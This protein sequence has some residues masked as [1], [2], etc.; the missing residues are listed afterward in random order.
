MRT[1]L[2]RRSIVLALGAAAAATTAAGCQTLPSLGANGLLH[3]ARHRLDASQRA[4]A[5]A[6]VYQAGAV[7]LAGWRL[8]ASGPRRGTIVYLHGVADNRAGAVG[9]AARFNP[10]GFDVVAYDSRAHGDSGGDVCTYGYYEKRDLQRV[11]DVL[12]SGPFILIGSSL[13]AAVALQ[14]A[15]EDARIS[16]VVAAEAFS[17]LATVARERAPW[18]FTRGSI[19][20]AL[21]LAERTGNFKIDEV[22]PAAAAGRISIPVLLIHGARDGETPPIHSQRIF[23]A[24]RG[25]RRL[26]I[27]DG[28]GH[29]QSLHA[30]W[31][32][33]ERWIDEVIAPLASAVR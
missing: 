19:R 5:P 6:V 29:N 9:V 33:I 30:S 24:L 25:P 10:R 1:G 28:A 21:D 7:A 3:P 16:A 4:A 17:D 13:G 27:V 12:D 11:L 2:M 15:A 14:T 31:P 23:D 18:F 20:R 26:S 8:P 22:S 32:E